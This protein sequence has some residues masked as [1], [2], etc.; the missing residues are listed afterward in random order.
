MIDAEPISENGEHKHFHATGRGGAGN[1]QLGD[2]KQG[3]GGE[4]DESPEAVREARDAVA[5]T[6][7]EHGVRPTGRG[8]SGNM[9][10]SRSRSRSRDPA[11]RTA[12]DADHHQLNRVTSGQLGP[13]HDEEE[14]KAMQEDAIARDRYLREKEQTTTYFASGRGGAGSK[15]LLPCQLSFNVADRRITLLADISVRRPV[16]PIGGMAA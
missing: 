12:A 6:L 15:Y 16:N 10:S 2:A 5:R 14:I 1:I 8:G 9:T 11:T 4:A 3:A 7:P 13:V